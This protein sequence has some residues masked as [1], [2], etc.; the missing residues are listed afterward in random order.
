MEAA[1]SAGAAQDTAA[2]NGHSPEDGDDE[3]IQA[4]VLEGDTAQL[5]LSVGGKKPTVSK[6]S[7]VGGKLEI[8]GQV[9]KGQVIRATVE[10]RVGGVAFEDKIDSGTQEPVGCTRTHK[11]RVVGFARLKDGEG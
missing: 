10:L 7:L 6:C 9:E 11:L 1:T 5:S 8:E 4:L 2:G 3:R